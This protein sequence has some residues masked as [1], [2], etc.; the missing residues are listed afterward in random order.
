MG[1]MLDRLE[2]ITQPTD[3]QKPAFDKLKDAAAKAH[4]AVKAACP[5]GPRPVTPPGRLAA[6]EKRLE[7]LLAGV[8]IV[9]GP[10]EEYYGS[11]SEEQ[12]ARLYMSRGRG[13]QGGFDRRRDRGDRDWQRRGPDEERDGAREHRRE[14]FNDRGERG[15]QG[16]PHRNDRDRDGWPDDWR[17]RS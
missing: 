3:A 17:G 13:W 15:G 16:S 7:A 11:L 4:E 5:S 9:R 8:R 1:F 10:L 2:R 6:A 14:G 12:K